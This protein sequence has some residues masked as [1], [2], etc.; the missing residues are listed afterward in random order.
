MNR[1][2]W[3]L[4]ATVLMLI[5]PSVIG[6]SLH[7]PQPLW[8]I[9][10]STAPSALYPE[11]AHSHWVWLSSDQSTEASVRDF[12]KGFQDHN[13]TV[14]AIDIDSKWSTGI[15]NFIWDPKKFPTA[16]QLIAD[17]HK[18][19]IRVILWTTS[20]INNDSPNYI[21]GKN[22]SY[23]LNDGKQI[24]WW[25]GHGSFIDYSNKDA[26]DWWH[27]QMDKVIDMGIDGWK[28]DGTDPFV[29]ELLPYAYGKHGYISQRQYANSYYRDFFYYTRSKNPDALIMARP[30]DG[31]DIYKDFE[32]I[33]WDFAPRDVVFSGWVGDDDPDFEG[34]RSA[35]ISIFR[36]AW[37]NYVNFGSDIGGYR[38]GPGKLGRTKELFIRW[39]QL[40]AMT[41]LMEVLENYFLHAC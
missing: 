13:I 37:A 22:K 2:C 6:T 21:E 29:F 1:T 14:G 31:F 8:D 38:T 35:L 10:S 27:K 7:L 28:C 40:G 34:L 33:Y 16:K 20:M 19:D 15:N 17:M 9:P 39:A 23:Y 41:P 26:L 32:P 4:V 18:M 3:Q 30:V 5:T 24:H 25:H 12:V 36:S 11:W